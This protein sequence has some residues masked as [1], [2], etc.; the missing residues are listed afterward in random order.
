MTATVLAAAIGSIAMGLFARLPYALAPGM[1]INAFFTF[2]L[3]KGSRSSP[4]RPW[5]W[6]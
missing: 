1:G 4:R 2:K 3:V 5:G 6:S